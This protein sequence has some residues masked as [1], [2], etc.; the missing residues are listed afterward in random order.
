MAILLPGGDIAMSDH[1]R[2]SASGA[3]VTNH[4][5]LPSYRSRAKSSTHSLRLSVR[6]IFYGYQPHICTSRVCE[7]HE[8]HGVGSTENTQVALDIPHL[9][10]DSLFIEA[11]TDG[12]L[13]DHLVLSLRLHE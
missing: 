13:P 1:S 4:T 12:G 9:A 8:R 2:F 3:L 11:Y 10:L 5:A 7:D 6:I